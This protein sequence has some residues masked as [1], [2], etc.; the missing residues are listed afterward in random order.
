MTSIAYISREITMEK[1]LEDKLKESYQLYESV[2]RNVDLGIIT[3]DLD[4]NILTF[5]E[6]S[7]KIFGWKESEVIGKSV[8]I[9][10]R[11]EDRDV[12]IPQVLNDAREKGKYEG[13]V[14][15]V[16]KNKEEFLASL[17]ITPILDS[18]KESKGYIGIL[19][20]LA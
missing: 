16:R 3:I 7:E 19:K 10:H 8:K 18:L 12:F 6:G 1:K 13:I 17:T 15:P 14:T 4:H 2:V 9:L 20:E 11:Q 5:N